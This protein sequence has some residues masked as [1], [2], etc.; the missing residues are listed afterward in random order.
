MPYINCAGEK[1]RRLQEIDRTRANLQIKLDEQIR[2]SIELIAGVG[3]AS[4]QADEL[5]RNNPEVSRLRENLDILISR[6]ADQYDEKWLSKVDDL[7]I[8][9]AKATAA[10]ADKRYN[11]VL[12]LITQSDIIIEREGTTSQIN[13][14]LS[15]LKVRGDA[16]LQMDNWAE[17]NEHYQRIFHIKFADLDNIEKICFCYQK[18]NDLKNA[19]SVANDLVTLVEKVQDRARIESVP[20]IA[21]TMTPNLASALTMRGEI[22]NKLHKYDLSMIDLDRANALYEHLVANGRADLENYYAAA[23]T[24]RSHTHNDLNSTQNALNDINKAIEI[25]RRLVNSGKSNIQEPLANTLND[26][27]TIFDKLN[28]Y[29]AAI[30]DFNESISI[31]H[32]LI[33]EGQNNLWDEIAGTITNLG[34]AVF[35]NGQH[36]DGLKNLDESIS[37]ITKLLRESR[38]DLRP[39]Y[40]RAMSNRGRA[41]SQLDQNTK[42]LEDYKIAVNTLEDLVA[43]GQ[44]DVAGDLAGE[45]GNRG[46]IYRRLTQTDEALKDFDKAMAIYDGLIAGGRTDL[47]IALAS[48]LQN[49]ASMV[50]PTNYKAALGDYDRSSKLYLKLLDSGHPNEIDIEDAVNLVAEYC[51][52][53]HKHKQYNDALHNYNLCHDVLD[54]IKAHKNHKAYYIATLVRRAVVKKD[55][56]DLSGAVKDIREAESLTS[57]DAIEQV[58][59]EYSKKLAH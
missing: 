21:T 3:K 18:M 1:E 7:R 58:F 54:K 2:R 12:K 53:L 8:R 29:K 34:N 50:A 48:V 35:D 19:I 9:L 51:L 28:K 13:R 55:M 31:R 15:I 10:A 43:S 56:G 49:R 23:L 32:K 37:I 30:A 16:L 38:Y 14:E 25:R 6:F 44:T 4:G 57:K 52:F 24:N 41:F 5:A 46:E 11:D 20:D 59:V 17:A 40:A 45:L 36:T 22:L 42:A 26:R 27:G 33:N 47:D 39:L